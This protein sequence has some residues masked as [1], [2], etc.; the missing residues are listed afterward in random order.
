MTNVNV[1]CMPCKWATSLR[2]ARLSGQVGGVFCLPFMG[3]FQPRSTPHLLTLYSF[4]QRVNVQRAAISGYS[5]IP[6]AQ[7]PRLHDRAT[8]YG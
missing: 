8:R 3:L 7:P 4:C 5:L 2:A 1:R 6:V